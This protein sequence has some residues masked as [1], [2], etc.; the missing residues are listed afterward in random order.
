MH[1]PGLKINIKLVV[2]PQTC[3][4]VKKNCVCVRVWVR[5]RE[6]TGLVIGPLAACTKAA[7]SLAYATLK[8]IATDPTFKSISL[9]WIRI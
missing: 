5:E 7:K 8:P 4:Y 3:L 9:V 6:I 1:Q 2:H